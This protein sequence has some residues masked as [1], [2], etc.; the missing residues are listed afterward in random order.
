MARCVEAGGCEAI[1]QMNTADDALP[2]LNVSW[3]DAPAYANWLSEKT[4]E[5]YRLPSEAEWEYAARAGTKTPYWWGERGSAPTMS[6]ARIAAANAQG[7]RPPAAMLLTP[8]ASAFRHE[9]RRGRMGHGLLETNYAGAADD[10]S[11]RV[12][13]SCTRRV[14]R[15]GSW[16]D[17]QKHITASSRGLLRPRRALSQQRLPRRAA[18]SNSRGERRAH[19]TVIVIFFESAADRGA[20]DPCRP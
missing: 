2:M 16:R 12:G 19:F 20:C 4:G 1:S 5:A 7:C 10:G 9:R 15:G 17:D 6:T 8:T 3:D 18:K 11:A 14:L 13:D